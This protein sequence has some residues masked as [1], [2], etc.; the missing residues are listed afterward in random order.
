MI[1]INLTYWQFSLLIILVIVGLF[2]IKFT[3]YYIL[4]QV[5]K[6]KL[7]NYNKNKKT[8]VLKNF[9]LLLEFVKLIDSKLVNRNQRRV[10]WNDFIRH[11]EKRREIIE[12]FIKSIDK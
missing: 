2:L 9:Q 10:F 1:S 4:N 6:R 5:K 3:L 8:Q 12:R 11:P 7:R